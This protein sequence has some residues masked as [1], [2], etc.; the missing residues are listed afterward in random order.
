MLHHLTKPA[1]AAA[2]SLT[3]LQAGAAMVNWTDWTSVSTSGASGTMGGVTVT[4]SGTTNGV[5]QTGCGSGTIN[6][7]TE[8]N[9]AQ[10]PYTGGT[11][12][13]G[14][15]ACEQVGLSSATRVTISF[16]SAVD[17][18]YMALLSVGQPGLAVTYDF[19]Q[20]FTV[21][22]AGV[23]YWSSGVPG[24]YSL[25]AGD[26]MTMR[27]FHGMLRFSGAGITGLSFTTNPNEFWHAFTL[28]T[29][30]PVSAPGSLALAGLAL[31][32]LGLAARRR[33]R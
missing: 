11:V 23:G 19:D 6:Y 28:G 4:V 31:A 17:S 9:A 20:S 14:P 15:T 5:S 33:A 25:G 21:D 3:A 32:G 12:S 29:A 7:W 26:T 1:L 27:E 2:L 8:P 24:T 18:L 30:A 22:S 16:S 13:N 10:K